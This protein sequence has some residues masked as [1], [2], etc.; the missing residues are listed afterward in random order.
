V[1][2][3]LTVA[4]VAA[5]PFPQDRGTPVRIQRTAEALAARGHAIHVITYPHGTGDVNGDV[6][7]HRIRGRR[8][9]RELAAGPTYRKLLMFDPMLALTLRG[10]LRR[11]TVDVIHAHHYE[12]LLVAAAARG[13]SRIPLVYDAHTLLA[14]ELPYYDLGLPSGVKRF[15]AAKLDRG[16]VRL[17]DHVVSVTDTIRDKLVASGVVSS[18]RVTVVTNGVELEL[19]DAGIAA[20]GE[21]RSD[22]KTLVFSGNLSPYQGI[23]LMIDAFARV[24]ERRQDVRL[25]IVTRSPFDSYEGRARDL[26]VRQ[27]IEIVP[28]DFDQ[29]PTLL[30]GGQVALNPRIDCDGIPLKLLNYMAAARPVVSFRSSAPVMQHERTGWLVPDGDVAGFADGILRLLD[31]SELAARL[32][33]NARQHVERH[34]TWEH[35]AETIESVYRRLLRARDPARV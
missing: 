35:A 34:H 20:A 11:H 22:V 17:P 33:R 4:I 26:G 28:A 6:A 2:H 29:V 30:A 21:P 15:V 13:R 14:S 3:G 23:D 5:C 7:V 31:D 24:R 12:G 10:F 1:K 25:Q 19:F 8:N 16:A 27:A 9:N 18:E 32:G